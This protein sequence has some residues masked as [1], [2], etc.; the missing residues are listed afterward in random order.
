MTNTRDMVIYW[1]NNGSMN[2]ATN[3]S[4]YYNCKLNFKTLVYIFSL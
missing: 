4:T 3:T 1:V 2:N